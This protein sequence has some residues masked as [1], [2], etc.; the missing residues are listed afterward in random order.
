[1]R[2]RVQSQAVSDPTFGS[3]DR[4]P[5]ESTLD[6][7]LEQ[8]LQLL[9]ILA[10]DP[11]QYRYPRLQTNWHNARPRFATQEIHLWNQKQLV[12]CYQIGKKALQCHARL[13]HSTESPLR[14]MD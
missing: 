14:A 9:P 6:S 13:L 3:A 5:Q 2:H 7:R 8:N 10:T 1:M 12:H 11:K 4:T